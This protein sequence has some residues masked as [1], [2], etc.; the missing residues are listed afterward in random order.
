MSPSNR[1]LDR[2][3]LENLSGLLSDALG[4]TQQL[5]SNVM[6]DDTLCISGTSGPTFVVKIVANPSRPAV[7]DRWRR[8][9][10]DS[11]QSDRVPVLVL[12]RIPPSLRD[13]VAHERIN[14]IDI[15][16]N[17]FIAAPPLLIHVEGKHR[18]RRD[19]AGTVDPFAPQSSNLVRLMLVE[20]ERAWRQKELVERTG[21]SQPRASKVL[22]ALR[23]MELVTHEDGRFSIVDRGALLDAWSDGYRYRRL[24]IAPAH[25]SGD[26][27]QLA[28]G[29]D[30]LLREANIT[31]WFTGL[32][33][34]WAYDQFARFRLVSVFVDGDPELVRADLGLRTAERG[35]NV[36]LIGAGLQ[37]LE[38]GQAWPEGLPCV[39]PIQAYLDLLDLPERAQEAADNLRPLALQWRYPRQ[40]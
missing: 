1:N 23:E 22:A 4:Q 15:A 20:P 17:A 13:L 39:H 8:L 19:T 28:R 3:A 14:W 18:P 37:K 2:V 40:S 25:L 29:L 26:G 10:S 35:A 16:G 38:I 34:A 9:R 32:P 27:M 24:D 30:E 21:V 36:H 11:A 6:P 7:L 5:R 12:P 33:A 31:H